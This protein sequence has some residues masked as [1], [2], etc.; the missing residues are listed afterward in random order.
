MGGYEVVMGATFLNKG[1]VETHLWVKVR[2]RF[3][4]SGSHN[5]MVTGAEVLHQHSYFGMHC[6]HLPIL[7]YNS[8][9]LS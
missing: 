6:I 3:Y 9:P 4:A 2:I 1:Y 8:A 5:N 7:W